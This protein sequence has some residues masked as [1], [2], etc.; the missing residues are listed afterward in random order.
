M[1]IKIA[2]GVALGILLIGIVIL[3]LLTVWVLWSKW[4][5][6]HL[7]MDEKDDDIW[8]PAEDDSARQRLENASDRFRIL[9]NNCGRN[10]DQ[11][12]TKRPALR[13][14]AKSVTVDEDYYTEEDFDLPEMDKDI[15]AKQMEQEVK[16]RIKDWFAKNDI[17]MQEE[18]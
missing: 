11:I 6:K 9:V 15:Q 18:E 17:E 3:V 10:S 7:E 16:E 4:M 13:N 8:E 12:I 5:E 1:I 2:A 14:E